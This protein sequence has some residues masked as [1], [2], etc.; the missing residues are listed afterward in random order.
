MCVGWT[1]TYARCFFIR[2]FDMTD[3]E[4]RD[5]LKQLGANET[6]INKVSESLD[7]EKLTMIVEGAK[8][9][10]EAIAAIG[11]AFPFIDVKEL[12]KRYDFIFGQASAASKEAK[13][14][15]PVQ[16]TKEELENV[17]GGSSVG[18][19]L[20]KNWRGVVVGA[21]LGLCLGVFTAGVGV[22]IHAAGFAGFSACSPAAMSLSGL[23]YLVAP[24]VTV[25]TKLVVASTALAF[26]AGLGVAG[27]HV[28]ESL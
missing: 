10:E 24:S 15:A 18:D 8:N 28:E 9:S 7:A 26:A 19:W 11:K 1:R 2:R 6:D 25:A 17:A 12:Q 27:G 21:V 14:K 22:G 5:V 13:S 20:K 4:M 16:L 3:A 23:A